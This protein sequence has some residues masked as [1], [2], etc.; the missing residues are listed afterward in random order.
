M[1][2]GRICV[3]ISMIPAMNTKWF[4]L[5]IS[6]IYS[7]LKMWLERIQMDWNADKYKSKS[8]KMLQEVFIRLSSVWIIKFNF[9][10]P[11]NQLR[12]GF[13][14]Y[15]KID[16]FGNRFLTIHEIPSALIT[17]SIFA[18]EGVW[19][20]WFW[21]AYVRQSS[22]SFPSW[23]HELKHWEA[24][25]G[26][27]NKHSANIYVTQRNLTKCRVTKYVSLF[28]SEL[29]IW[30]NRQV[31]LFQLVPWPCFYTNFPRPADP[32]RWRLD[33]ISSD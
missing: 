8:H 23:C 20:F 16:S 2:C 6:E 27:T 17:R 24:R 22:E 9:P 29:N 14:G 3:K 30:M 13:V 10:R 21:P 26:D 31:Y 7:R 11:L 19:W 32:K 1:L 28:H 33:I 15:L 18:H 25:Y 12:V 4:V 5:A